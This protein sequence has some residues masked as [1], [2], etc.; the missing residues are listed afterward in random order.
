MAGRGPE[1][2]V[3]Y[4]GS[5]LSTFFASD[6]DDG[7]TRA[8]RRR[9]R[10]RRRRR[11]R[12]PLGALLVLLVI[13]GLVAGIVYGGRSVLT[14]LGTVP[15]YPGAGTGSVRVEV[16]RGDTASDIAATLARAGVVKSERA[17]REAAK[18][19][20][21]SVGIQPGYYRLRKQMSGVAAL[22]MLL[23]PASRLLSRVTV[24]EGLIAAEILKLLAAK[25][26]RSLA[27]LQAAARD[28]AMLGLPGYARGRLEGFLF[29]ATYDFD[30]GTRPAEMLR[31][32]VAT[33]RDKVDE[34]ALAAAAKALGLSP[35]QLLT[36]GS[37]VEEEAVT[38]DFAKVARVIYNRLHRGQRLELDSTVNYA[39]G[40]NRVRVST[41]DLQVSSP[42]NTYRQE[43]LP[44]TPISN[45]GLGAIDAAVHPTAGPWLYFVKADKSGRSY[46]T[47]DYQDF[48]RAKARAQAAGVY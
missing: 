31:Q 28:T 48:L 11:R 33:Y 1:G 27:A 22:G 14:R 8:Q 5:E 10:R 29:P 45:P 19:D 38:P 4:G 40:R 12:G 32:M 2:A 15:D 41:K 37:L 13:G 7:H 46:F 35:Y 39:L 21:R 23:D 30:P 25:T 44:P 9:Q 3:T 26:G 20:P 47:A 34:Q 42:Y 16:Q 24:P 43:G 17:F 18:D 36:V 6:Y